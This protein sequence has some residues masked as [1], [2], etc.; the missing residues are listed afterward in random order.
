[1]Y[2]EWS[3]DIIISLCVPGIVLH[4]KVLFPNCGLFK[5]VENESPGIRHCRSLDPD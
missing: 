2:S 1:M 4:Q 5:F 3:V